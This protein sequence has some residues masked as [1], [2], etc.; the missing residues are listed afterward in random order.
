[1]TGIALIIAFIVAIVVMI[2]AIS[3]LKIHP[4]LSIMSVS[5]LLGLVAGIPLTDVKVDGVVQTQGLASVIGAGFSG[6]FTSIG[7]VIILGA[8][9]GTILEKTGAA[10]K[11]ADMTVK[12][13]GK[14]R[15]ELAMLI[16]GWVVSI[17]V[18]CDSGFVILNPI[19]KALVKKTMTSSVAMTVALA[20]GLYVSHVLIPPTPGPIAAAN[21]LGAGDNLLLV[22]GM[23]ALC[24]IFPLIAGYF[25]AKFIGSKVK[26]NDEANLDNGE[27]VQ[28]YDELVKSYGQLPNAFMSFSPIVVP[29]LLMGISS[30][31]A[32]AKMTGLLAQVL[33]FLGT[34]IIA[35]AIGTIF[36]VITLASAKRMKDFNEMTNDTLKVVGPILFVTAAGGV[37]G[38]VIAVSGLVSF[39]TDNASVFQTIGIFFPFLLA[40]ILKTA[41]GSS[42]VAITTTAGILAPMLPVL[43][44]DTP[45]L[46]VLT[47]MAIGAG[48]MVVSHANDSYFW[49]VTNFGAMTPDKGYK[50]Q[51][52]MTLVMGV[53]AI[54]EIFL[55]TLVLH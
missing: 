21:T 32:M 27:I 30:V 35:L 2:L 38:K 5:L 8:L 16:M 3:K 36:G 18:F 39:I 14:K 37:L 7:I 9:I 31:A 52:M 26:S 25:Y 15:P 47:V 44:L 42:T 12:L 54:L 13:V 1:M 55:L 28:S 4:F 48:A 10:L 19:R 23:G 17:P 34:P 24:S 46:T 49:V 53:A 43:G 50:T 45:V 20:G 40:A 41:Q 51:T 33:T 22:I 29:I 11:L 6:T